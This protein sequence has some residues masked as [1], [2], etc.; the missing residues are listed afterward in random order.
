MN[1]K[2]REDILTD[3]DPLRRLRWSDTVRNI[4]IHNPGV[5]LTVWCDEDTPLIWP[6]VLQAVS[7]HAPAIGAGR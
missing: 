2:G 3:V 7:G 1:A 6:E 5:P 4:R